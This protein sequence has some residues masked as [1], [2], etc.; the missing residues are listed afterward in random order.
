MLTKST[1]PPCALRC[2]CAVT[3]TRD[4]PFLPTPAAPRF[5]TAT[6]W[7]DPVWGKPLKPRTVT[8]PR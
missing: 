3:L 4:L 8:S 6:V 1:C 7:G 5:H 2:F